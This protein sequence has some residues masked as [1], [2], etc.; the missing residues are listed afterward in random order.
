MV[1]FVCLGLLGRQP[2]SKILEHPPLSGR[3]LIGMPF[4]CQSV[5]L[6][7][8]QS[9][10]NTFVSAP[11]LLNPFL[12][13]ISWNFTHMFLLVRL[14][15][16]PMPRLHSLK[17]K[18]TIQGHVINPSICVRSIS[19]KPFELVSLNFSTWPSHIDSRSLVK[20]KGFILEFGV[21]SISPEPWG[22]FF[23]KLHLNVPHSETACR[24]FEL[25]TKTQGHTSRSCALSFNLCPLHI[26]C[27]LE[28]FQLDFT[29][30]FL[31]ANVQN[32]WPGCASL[33]Q[34]YTSRSCDLPPGF[35]RY[36]VSTPHHLNP[37]N[38]FH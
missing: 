20:V 12:W 35:T 1:C 24:L 34:A 18:V 25:A 29:Q 9:V 6:C 3:W 23:M 11:Y 37:S 8:R 33:C 17:V 5:N 10:H 7:V 27:P 19:P 30:M 38:D 32:L 21:C 13:S 16:E 26:S 22:Q 31:S 15:A 14:C 4:V 28:W 36:F 2:V